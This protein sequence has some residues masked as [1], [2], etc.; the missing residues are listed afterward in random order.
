MIIDTRVMPAAS[1][2]AIGSPSATPVSRQKL[3]VEPL[4]AAP[5]GMMQPQNCRHAQFPSHPGAADRRQRA[6]W[7][8]QGW[9]RPKSTTSITATKLSA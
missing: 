9:I 1:I 4:P 3:A 8:S 6:A 2:T 7:R 5:E